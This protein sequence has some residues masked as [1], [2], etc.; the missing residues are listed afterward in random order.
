M[1]AIAANTG[2]IYFGD[3]ET[4]GALA[5]HALGVVSEDFMSI[6]GDAVLVN[7]TDGMRVTISLPTEGDA[8]FLV[9]VNEQGDIQYS[10]HNPVTGAID[11][12]VRE[13]GIYK[14]RENTV[15]FADIS[16][17]S[18]LMQDAILQLAARG[19]MRGTAEERFSPDNLITRAEFVS[20]IV[21]AFDM[22]D[23]DAQTSFIDVTPSNW[24]SQAIATAENSRLINGFE[25]N[26]FRGGLDIP[27]D[28]L[29]VVAANTLVQ[30]MGYN[31][32][33]DI[34]GILAR[35]PDRA[36]LAAWA[37]GG[38]AL[39]TVSNV[40]IQRTDS[41][42]TPQSVMTRGDAAIVLHRVFG[43]VW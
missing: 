41:L 13:S 11:A 31:V 2:L 37:D 42:F 14:L 36:Q 30:R 23:L 25:D 7:M 21:M 26:T 8:E 17:K 19:I 34:E 16:D 22:L 18:Q 6:E 33:S 15:S 40:L 27:K 39:A 5:V 32:P 12:N 4:T 3:D 38:V 28:Q 43:R 1:L 20:A 10:K 35:Y 29:V 24:Y 9:L